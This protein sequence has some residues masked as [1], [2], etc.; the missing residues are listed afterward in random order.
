MSLTCYRPTGFAVY[1]VCLHFV[2][3]VSIEF[4]KMDYENSTLNQNV[5][6]IFKTILNYSTSSATF[7]DPTF[8]LAVTIEFY[9]QYAVLGIGVFGMAANA[10]VLYALIAEH[11]ENTKKR[12]INLLIINQNVLDLCSC[13]LV[14]VTYSIGLR[15]YLTGALGYF[16]CTVFVSDG[17]LYCTLFASVINLITLTVERYLKVVHPFW[18]K[19]NLKHWMIHA[20]MVFAWTGGT[21]FT[22]IPAFITTTVEDGIC[23]SFQVWESPAAH[24]VYAV[25]INLFFF[26]IPL[27]IFVYCCSRIVIVMRRQMR[28]MAGHNVEAGRAQMSASQMQSKRIK[29]NI[30]KTMIIVSVTFTI[31]WFPNT[32]YFMIVDITAPTG[33]LF[34]GYFLTVFMAYL[35]ISMNPFIYALKHDGVKQRL[36]RM[37]ICRKGVV[38]GN[39][40]G[41]ASNNDAGTTQRIQVH[42]AQ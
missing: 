25:S 29:W 38:V 2:Y 6:N 32:V 13:V 16:L 37:I 27:V 8:Q 22:A 42:T 40:S 1:N 35:N 17:A 21:L 10:V 30:I 24:K 39:D 33:S 34:V 15:V 9:F 31:C 11:A 28:V 19:K 41:T 7:F 4:E 12:A 26:F 3:T 23:L 20:A 5:S 36:A 18:S 14:V